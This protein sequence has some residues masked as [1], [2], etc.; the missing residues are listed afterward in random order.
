VYRS[1]RNSLKA[2]LLHSD[3]RS[4]PLCSIH[5]CRVPLQHGHCAA[6]GWQFCCTA[7]DRRRALRVI[8]FHVIKT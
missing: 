2:E 3:W 6:W 4:R 1:K 7:T 5:S 8:A